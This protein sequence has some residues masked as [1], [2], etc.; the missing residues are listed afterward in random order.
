M[1]SR[2]NSNN[3]N[4]TTA[5]SKNHDINMLLKRV[6]TQKRVRVS[7]LVDLLNILPRP[8]NSVLIN[9]KKARLYRIIKNRNTSRLRN[10]VSLN[11]LVVIHPELR[12]VARAFS[13]TRLRMHS[14]LLIEHILI[15]I[16]DY[17]DIINSN[18]NWSMSNNTIK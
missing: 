9:N 14:N 4:M 13:F 11:S 2:E 8:S 5:N 18:S 17:W 12:R 16:D 6:S 1:S 7:S 15:A 3:S 10:Q